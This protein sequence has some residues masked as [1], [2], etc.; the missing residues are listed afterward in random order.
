MKVGDI[1]LIGLAHPGKMNL[2]VLSKLKL[3][4]AVLTF[5]NAEVVHTRMSAGY[6][7]NV[8]LPLPI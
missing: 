8:E 7:H 4:L 3:G 1:L 2:F 5:L 6:V